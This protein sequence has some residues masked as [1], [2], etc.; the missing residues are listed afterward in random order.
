[1]EAAGQAIEVAKVNAARHLTDT[2]LGTAGVAPLSIREAR[3]AAIEAADHLE[4][5][6]AA[7][8]ALNSER[9]EG[10]EGLSAILVTDAARAVIKAEVSGRVAAMASRVA[11]LQRQLVAAGSALEWLSSRGALPPVARGEV[12]PIGRTVGL[13]RVPPTEWAL[14]GT[15]RY[16]TSFA[17]PTGAVAWEA[18]F[19]ALKRDATTLLPEVGVDGG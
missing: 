2:A 11:E 19:E 18:A 12:D 10:H 16:S 4:A 6:V 15:V 14:G 3:T 13:L 5:C 8:D 9:A 7:R 1:V 17:E